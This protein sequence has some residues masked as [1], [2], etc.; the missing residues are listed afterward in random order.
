MF[1]AKHIKISLH[2]FLYVSMALSVYWMTQA[3]DDIY[4]LDFLDAAI[5]SVYFQAIAA[6]SI[7]TLL[8][9]TKLEDIDFEVYR[10]SPA[11]S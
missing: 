3:A 7:G 11:A 2:S 1:S 10:D 5:M 6:L 8:R 9:N 4:N